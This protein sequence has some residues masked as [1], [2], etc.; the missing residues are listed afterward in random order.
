MN[1]LSHVCWITA[2]IAVTSFACGVA[3]AKTPPDYWP[4]EEWRVSTPEEQGLNSGRLADLL[5]TI[6]DEGHRIR[7]VV[8]IRNGYV[9]LDAPFHPYGRDMRHIIH[10]CTKTITSALVG[11]AI[12]KGFIENVDQRVLDFFPEKTAKNLDSQKGSIT[13]EHLLTMSS[14]LECRDSYLYDWQGLGEMTRSWDWVQHMLD[15]PIEHAPGTRFEY[16]NGAS[17]LLSAILQKSTGKTAF[18]FAK[19]HL[20]GP[21]GIEDVAWP[22]SREGVSLGW[23]GIEMRPKDLAKIAFLYLNNGNW[24]GQQV[25]SSDWVERS[26][27]SRIVAGTLSDSY[28]YHLWPNEA[29]YYMMLGYCGQ[30]V[31]VH[32]KNNLIVVVTSCLKSRDFFLP[33]YW[34]HEYILPAVE[35]SKSLPE[36]AE[37]TGRIASVVESI[38]NPLPQ[39]VPPL[40]ATAMQ[41]SGK[42]YAFD[43]NPIQLKSISLRFDPREKEAR[44]NLVYGAMIIRT[45]VGLDDVYRVS[46]DAGHWRAYKG[47]W[48]EEKTFVIDF[49]VADHTERGRA[50]LTFEGDT[51]KALIRGE[52]QGREYELIG[53]VRR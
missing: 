31:I 49:D 12:D 43:T 25:V 19:E 53:R 52:I 5:E 51:L 21:L 29:G 26:T 9:V 28:G 15:L 22:T 24:N 39:S 3:S 48:E 47:R 41:I 2:V 18:A 27:Q 13:L 10:S 46:Y 23:G 14:G 45:N 36:D 8:V 11:I 33:R 44:L 35:S 42:R 17:Y 50:H 20:F 34:L 16:C 30:Y 7:N 38:S 1:K 32:P 4:T 6:R 37:G 40:P